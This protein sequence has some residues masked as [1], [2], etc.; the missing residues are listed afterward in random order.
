MPIK[1]NIK[2]RIFNNYCIRNPLFSFYEYE[3]R[4]KQ[5]VVTSY[6]LKELLKNVTFKEALFLASPELITQIKKWEEGKVKDLHKVEQLK[7]T[8]LKYFTRSTTRCTPFGLFAS[9]SVGS[10][11]TKTNINLSNK[12]LRF[13]R[14]DTTFL[15]QLLQEL[16]KNEQIKENILFYPNTSIYKIGNHFRYVEYNIKNNKR[17]YSLEG[18]IFSKHLE[19]ILIEAKKGCTITTL[20][21][22]LIND[23]TTIEEAKSYVNQLIE[24]QILVSELEINVTGNDYFTSLLD[25][26]EKIPKALPTY[27]QLKKIQNR[28]SILDNINENPTSDY[29]S[30]INEAKKLVPELET[31]YLFQTDSFKV[32]KNNSLNSNL[33]KQLEKA[34]IFFNAITIPAAN[35]NIETFKRNF[36]KRF[37][38]AEIPLSLVLDSETGIG[39]GGKRNDNNDLLDNLVPPISK[40]RYERVIWTDVDTILQQKLINATKNNNYIIELIEKDFKDFPLNWND[41]PDTFSSI[42]EVYKSDNKEQVFIKGVSGSSAVNLLGRFSYTNKELLKHIKEIIAVEEIINADKILAEIVHLPEARTGNILHRASFRKYELPYLGKASVENKYQIPLEDILVSVKN[43]RI[44]LRSKRLNKEILPRLGNAHNYSNN[45]LPVYQFLCDL[46]TQD[47]RAA[48]GFNWNPI[49]EKQPFLPRVIY[50]NCI[51]S[52]AR[53]KIDVKRF[54]TLFEK[55]DLLLEINKWKNRLMIPDYV[56][57]V[58]GDNKLLICLTNDTSVKMLLQTIKNKKQFILE[59]FLF[60]TDEFITDENENSFCNQFIISFYNENKLKIAQNEQ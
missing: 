9:C 13:T 21:F 47:K 60:S 7:F 27:I 33:Q 12:L 43:N 18:V 25:R 17:S 10:F 22:I 19:K 29:L 48:I 20:S 3:K 45:P 5:E 49:L 28:L 58:D 37:E 31:K 30:I 44:L 16:L 52:K 39:Y 24:A 51:F 14:F 50:E 57:L 15:T 32:F 11:G 46:Q 2:Y 55:K 4:L 53:W 54:K 8:I 36:S 6:C 40:K 35:G 41:L 42:I 38:E 34:L 59:E 23:E 26:I 56:E 1:T